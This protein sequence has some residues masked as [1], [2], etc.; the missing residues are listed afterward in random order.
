MPKVP[1]SEVD[2][3][4][5]ADDVYV[6]PKRTYKGRICGAQT[7]HNHERNQGFYQL[8]AGHQTDHPRQGRCKFH[9]GVV[10]RKHSRYSTIRSKLLQTLIEANATD[11]DPLD[12]IP[13]LAVARALLED[14]M[15]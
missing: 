14:S 1:K 7:R 5:D 13:D 10:P 9:G 6:S 3:R 11:P 8:P 12:L 15:N 2:K 4:I